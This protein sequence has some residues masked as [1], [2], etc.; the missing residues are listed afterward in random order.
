MIRGLF[1]KLYLIK[2]EEGLRVGGV[3]KWQAQS[4]DHFNKDDNFTNNILLL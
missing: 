4:C 1:I 3:E 2:R